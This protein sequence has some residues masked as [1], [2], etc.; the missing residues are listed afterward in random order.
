MIL[1]SIV[2]HPRENLILPGRLDKVLTLQ[3]EFTKGPFHC[4]QDN[5]V[6]TNCCFSLDGSKMVTYYGDNLFV[7]DVDSGIKEKCLPYDNILYSFSFTASGNFLGT[8]D[9]KNVFRVYDVRNNYKVTS[10]QLWDDYDLKFPVEIFS[11][12]EQNP[13]LCSVDRSLRCINHDLTLSDELGSA[14][15]VPLPGNLHSSGELERFFKNPDDTWLSRVQRDPATR[16]IPLGNKSV[17]VFSCGKNVVRV[18]N[19]DA[20]METKSYVYNLYGVD[21]STN[22]DFVYLNNG[23][24]GLTVTKLKNESSQFYARPKDSSYVVVKGGVISYMWLSPSTPVLWNSDFSQQLSSFHQLAGMNE[25]LSVSDEVIACVYEYKCVKFFNVSTKQIVHEMSFDKPFLHV[26]ACS[27]KYHAIMAEDRGPCFLWKDGGK[28]NAR[29]SLFGQAEL[30][31]ICAAEFSPEGNTLA[32]SFR[33][34]NKLF[35]FDV[36]ST[37]M[38]AQIAFAGEC[39]GVKYLDGRNLVC[40]F[41]ETIYFI[42][43]E[44]SEILA[45][46]DVYTAKNNFLILRKKKLVLRKFS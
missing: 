7:W 28:I 33:Y 17:L 23:S 46:L 30:G 3:E 31:Q 34:I 45:C 24:E 14:Y 29:A 40:S 22:G 15:S 42:N 20:L 37:S 19:V 32:L 21:I 13:R 10:I 38:L 25:C 11:T 16:Y 5:S 12:F 8:I 1:H 43:V 27:I 9:C 6:F 2:F 26:W 4:D 18:F 41:L 35:I 36:V 44:R 39:H